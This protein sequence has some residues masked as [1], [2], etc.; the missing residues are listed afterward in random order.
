MWQQGLYGAWEEGAAFLTCSL[1]HA[2][3]DDDDIL[4]VADEY[5]QSWMRWEY[6]VC[7]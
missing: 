1:P 3:T 7:C 6:K 2:Q 4:D 5:F